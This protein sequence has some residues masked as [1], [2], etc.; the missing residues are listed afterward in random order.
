VKRSSQFKQGRRNGIKWA[1]TW[2]HRRAAQMNDPHARLVLNSAA[3]AVGRHAKWTPT[4]QKSV[5][6]HKPT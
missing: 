3:Y 4:Q 2:L 1:V 6:E 5:K